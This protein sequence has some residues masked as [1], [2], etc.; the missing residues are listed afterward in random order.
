MITVGC[1][2]FPVPATRYFKELG[3]VEIQETH[4]AVPGTGTLR[5]W[6]REAPEG[7]RFAL[8]G[9]REIGQE[10]F[11]DG[12]V[13]D[14]ALKNLVEVAKELRA[15]TA[16]FVSPAELGPLKTSKTHVVEF[17]KGARK[18]FE[19]VVWEP[20]LAWDAEEAEGIAQDANVL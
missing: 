13:T 3:F 12:K 9:P 11:R 10:G 17:L 19:R 18:K 20:P 7:F 1:A 2:G 8:I 16:I 15:T 14:G 5:R 4:L 6:R